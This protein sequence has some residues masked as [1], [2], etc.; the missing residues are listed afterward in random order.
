MWHLLKRLADNLTSA[1]TAAM[2]SGFVFGL[3]VHAPYLKRLVIPLTFFMVLPVMMTLKMKDV[4]RGG[5]TKAQIIA[6]VINFVILPASAYGLGLIFFSDQPSMALG[7]L[8]IGL[9]PSSG[10]TI[11]WTGFARGSKETAVKM[12][13][14]GL[15][16]GAFLTPFYIQ[17]LLGASLETNIWALI[18]QV[19]LVIFLPLLLGYL[20]Q[21]GVLD[22]YGP[23]EFERTWAVRLP[24]IATAGLLL[25][26]FVVMALKA[27][28]IYAGPRIILNILIP[29]V[30]FYAISYGIGILAGRAML[31]RQE[32]IALIYGTVMRNLSIVLALAMNAF[33]DSGSS[34][35]LVISLAFI[36]QVQLAAWT[37]KR[38]D[39]IFSG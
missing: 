32:A 2:I 7:L 38:A 1:I 26:V 24:T 36:I 13:V 39:R 35:A 27:R 19:V 8:L 10:M 25:L 11:S 9:I 18:R 31:S 23:E 15:V 6:Q 33:G 5:D 34:A 12:T 16:R 29:L 3:L 17:V 14:F 20:V 37:A 28:F 4:F 30:I 22:H 21:K